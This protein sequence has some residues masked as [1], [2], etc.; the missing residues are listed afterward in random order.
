MAN[1]QQSIDIRVPVHTAYQQLTQFE[2]YPLFMEEV[3]AVRQLDDTHFHWTTT[4]SNRSVEWDSEITERQP[5]RCIA[6][7]NVSGPTNSGRVEL[8]AAGTDA[9]RVTLTLESRPEQVPGSMAGYSDE[10]M[11]RRLKLDLARLKDFIEDS[12]AQGEP[13]G[14][15]EREQGNARAPVRTSGF[16]AGSEGW[17]GNE[18]PTSPATSAQQSVAQQRNDAAN[19]SHPPPNAGPDAQAPRSTQSDNQLSRS[20]DIEIDDGPFSVSEE[21]SLDQ[22][23]DAVRHVGQ[24][25]QDT[26]AEPG[27]EIPV[28]DAMGKAMQQ[29]AQDA[30][31]DAKLKRSV[32]RAVPPSE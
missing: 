13:S 25:P 3:D 31:G 4:V 15:E 20:T 9:A 19:S 28:S 16:A 27:S 29:E 24:M 22:Q 12:A 10:E 5:D 14:R 32:D 21:V 8:Q 30:K 26:S 18:D 6:W 1:I 17:E 7:R 23:S 11:G 2:T